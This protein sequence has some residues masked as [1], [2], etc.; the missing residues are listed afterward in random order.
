VIVLQVLYVATLLRGTFFFVDDFLNFEIAREMDLSGAYLERSLFGHLEPGHRLG[1][2]VLVHFFGASHASAVV[3]TVILSAASTL[4]LW[5]LLR[6]LDPRSGW[7]L[8]V[9][10]GFAFTTSAVPSLLWWSAALNALPCTVGAIL[11]FDASLRWYLHGRSPRQL[12]L[13]VIGF[14]GAIS[15]Y[16]KISYLPLV[17]ALVI[18]VW[19]VEGSP[20]AR[21]REV[22]RR[23]LPL[24][25]SL[26]LPLLAYWGYYAHLGY[27]REVTIK[28]TPGQL[29]AYVWYA[30]VDGLVPLL[31]GLST[32]VARVGSYPLTAALCATALAVA[33]LLSHRRN[34]RAPAA[35]LVLLLVF[36]LNALLVGYARAGDLGT[37]Y[38]RETKYFGD[39]AW[40]MAVCVFLAASPGAGRVSASTAVRHT[41][42][43]VWR[44]GSTVAAAVVALLLVANTAWSTVRQRDTSI[45]KT[46]GADQA[47]LEQTWA[48]WHRDYPGAGIYDTTVPPEINLFRNGNAFYPYTQ[49]SRSAG[50][51]LP[52]VRWNS[53]DPLLVMTEHGALER[54]HFVPSAHAIPKPATG[55][56]AVVTPSPGH[57]LG[58]VDGGAKGGNITFALDRHVPAGSWF[59]QLTS[60]SP[61]EAEVVTLLV[62]DGHLADGPG[63]VVD[64]H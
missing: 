37:R 48:A 20:I 63:I 2:W 15:F 31:L 45:G 52:G 60:D 23:G 39:Y 29:A 8:P 10:A 46:S 40:L 42:S 27:S 19:Y 55:S 53:G 43:R 34:S 33:I 1:N 61:A 54:S 18:V 16:E 3:V 59:L 51:Y 7:L 58:C 32:P 50:R 49:L 41:A 56:S 64:G 13:A 25:L 22:V 28:A 21:I 17:V 4:L 12:V 11:A 62:V 26:G 47:R 6:L 14:V 30:F 24:W 38:G 44:R 36:L 5:R 57:K 9:T 35:W